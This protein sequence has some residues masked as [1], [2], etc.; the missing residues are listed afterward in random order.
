MEDV[1]TLVIRYDEGL[2]TGSYS[3]LLLLILVPLTTMSSVCLHHV[4]GLIIVPSELIP[5]PL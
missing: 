2:T 1:E 3:P 5:T 4:T